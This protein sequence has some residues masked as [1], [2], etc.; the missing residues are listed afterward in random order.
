MCV[1]KIT[2]KQIYDQDLNSCRAVSDL[3]SHRSIIFLNSQMEMPRNACA[4]CSRTLLTWS[5]D[6]AEAIH[7]YSRAVYCMVAQVLIF[8]LGRRL[9]MLACVQL[10]R[11]AKRGC[12]GGALAHLSWVCTLPCVS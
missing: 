12:A 2:E 7:G 11:C 9:C 6:A 4:K 8:S 1:I 3:R 10:A 5:L